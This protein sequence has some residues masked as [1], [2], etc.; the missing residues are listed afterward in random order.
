MSKPETRVSANNTPVPPES[1]PPA[2]LTLDEG[3]DNAGVIIPEDPKRYQVWRISGPSAHFSNPRLE[4]SLQMTTS[5]HLEAV[6]SSVL[7][8]RLENGR[9]YHAYKNGN[10]EQNMFLRTFGNRLGPAP[11]NEEK[12]NVGR[13]L[14]SGTGTGIWATDFGEEHPD[15]EVIGVDLSVTWPNYMPTNVRVEI[16]DLEEP[17]IFSQPLN[18]IHSRNMQAV[19]ID[20]ASYIKKCYDN[21]APG[22]YLEVNEVDLF[23]QS[24][25]GTLKDDSAILES[26]RLIHE[27]ST[28]FG[29]SPLK[30]EDL[31]EIMTSVGFEDVTAQK[32]KWHT[33]SW[34]KDAHYK[35]LGAWCHDNLV[36]G[37]EG[38]SMAPFTR[39]LNW[40]NKE[41]I[42]F[43][44]D[45]RKELA[46]KQIHAYF[47]VWSVYGRKSSTPKSP[48]VA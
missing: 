35:E 46:N 2:Q 5:R 17:W 12:S 3:G 45:V 8:Y 21:L 33:N 20:C 43:M 25:D 6:T 22:G 4:C 32:F 37:W 15:A 31:A 11:P 29:R 14:D 42:V 7:D 28:I 40:S 13:V 34:P 41:V 44:V 38:V 36:A 1:D 9:T 19:I 18:Y 48:T 39:A 27:C 10:L 26:T 24:D 30:L 23:P 16:D 47:S